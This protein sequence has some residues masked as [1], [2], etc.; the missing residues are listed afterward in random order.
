MF[1]RFWTLVATTFIETIRQPIYPVILGVTVMLLIL[2]VSLSAFTLESGGDDKLLLDLGLSTLL[3]SGLFLAAFSA[4]GVLSREI[5]NRTVLTVISKPVSRPLFILGKFL[6][7]VG[8]QLVAQYICTLVFFLTIRHGVMANTTDPWDLPVWI[9][10]GLAV[11]ISL[12]VAGFRNYLYGKHFPTAAISLAGVLLTMAL[13]LVA[14]FDKKL[15][16]IPFASDFIGGQVIIAAY[17][18]SLIVIIMTA[19]A[20]AASTRFG[21]VMTLLTCTCVLGVGI[22]ADYLFGGQLSGTGIGKWLCG[23]IPN[24]GPF[25]IIDGLTANSPDTTATLE[26]VIYVTAYGLLISTGIVALAIAAF[27]RRE[28]G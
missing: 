2:N 23:A 17:F 22:M 12:V 7:L 16:P 10:G 27:Q 24:V 18:V 3:L 6:G 19:V 5:E 15:E 21:Q 26:Y 9:F 1:Q 8:A 25:W 28:V 20:L 11:L 14:K 4:A 13:L